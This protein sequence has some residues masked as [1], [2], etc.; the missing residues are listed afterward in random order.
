MCARSEGGGGFVGIVRW[1]DD[2]RWED[3]DFDTRS[4]VSVSND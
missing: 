2:V 1:V 4:E 3:L